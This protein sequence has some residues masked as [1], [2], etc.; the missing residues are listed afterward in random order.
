MP[1][2]AGA[3]CWTPNRQGQ[4][5][6]MQIVA[7]DGT[8]LIV[9]MLAGGAFALAGLWLMFR[10]QP[11]GEAA[12]I[13]LFG[14]KVQASSAGL[15]VFLI[16]AAFLAVP[17]FVPERDTSDPVESPA[18]RPGGGPGG[19]RSDDGAADR[20]AIPLPLG[21]DVEEQEPNDTIATANAFGLGQTVRATLPPDDLDWFVFSTED[22][23]VE[24]IRI[25]FRNL[26]GDCPRY[27]LIDAVENRV[28]GAQ[29]CSF[30]ISDSRSVFVNGP[31][32]FV[33]VQSGSSR[34]T[35]ELAISAE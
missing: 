3:V 4:V 16:G 15:L 17:I 18:P 34:T 28:T 27:D 10:P 21:P 22:A 1:V 29:V 2:P 35:Y 13:E 19:T 11:A 33:R 25:T 24:S 5:R 26:G 12:R 20:T 31:R 23:D 6:T 30:A 9:L 32:Y 14:L 7:L 8:K